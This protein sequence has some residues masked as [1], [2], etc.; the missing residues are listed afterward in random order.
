MKQKIEAFFLFFQISMTLDVCTLTRFG[1][2]KGFKCK[3]LNK[4]KN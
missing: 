2:K 3:S 1:A 4:K